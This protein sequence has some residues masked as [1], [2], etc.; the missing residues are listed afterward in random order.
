MVLSPDGRKIAFDL[1]SLDESYVLMYDI[2]SGRLTISDMVSNGVSDLGWGDDQHILLSTY[3]VGEA[4]S[5]RMGEQYV[6]I[7]STH[8]ITCFD[9]SD[10]DV[11]WTNRVESTAIIFSSGFFELGDNVGYALGDKVFAFDVDTGDIIHE[12]IT[13]DSILLAN[14]QGHD[15]IPHM[16][17][18]DGAL[19]SP[20]PDTWG[21]DGV[22]FNYLFVDSIQN[23]SENHGLYV[24]QL[25]GTDIIYYTNDVY[26]HNWTM[27]S[28]SVYGSVQDRYVDN[29]V[30]S[31]ASLD[32]DGVRITVIDPNHND[33]IV[34]DEVLVSGSYSS[35]MKILGA[36]EEYV[37]I[38]YSS[39]EVSTLY[40]IKISNGRVYEDDLTSYRIPTDGII[41]LDGC[42]AYIDGIGSDCQMVVY[43]CKSGD[44]IECDLPMNGL[45][46]T[47]APVY[48]ADLGIVYVA[49]T[50]GD[51]IVDC[52][53]EDCER[54]D[55]P[56]NWARTS[57]V[58]TDSMSDRIV[59]TDGTR[60]LVVDRR[61]D[62]VY[63][64][65]IE[66]RNVIGLLVMEDE[67]YEDPILVTLYSDGYLC[68]YD[69]SNGTLLASTSVNH[70]SN[71]LPTVTFEVDRNSGYLYVNQE[72]LLSVVSLEDWVEHCHVEFYIGHHALT[73]RFFT[74]QRGTEGDVYVGY[75]HHYSLTELIRMATDILGTNTLPEEIIYRYGLDDSGN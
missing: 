65:N 31:F 63:E 40:K 36:D 60:V 62:I 22:S 46:I 73:D 21:A 51:Y 30:V 8:D 43:N 41:M 69:A 47:I 54:V 14:D 70:Y 25:Y 56:N 71:Y 53:S 23:I 61:G 55:L 59:I 16:F 15:G 13:N 9:S 11:L 42:I 66:G 29:N 10:L 6:L 35:D 57:V 4:S 44:T 32:S 3:A 18:R 58:A 1:S 38:L 49:S 19:G 7:P 64:I 37:Y 75:Y 68:K 39:Y 20:I 17:T 52:D 45:N 26:D 33:N 28:D 27:V 72:D 67:N 2:P 34:F 50:E 5:Y 48:D 74:F 24:S 12:W